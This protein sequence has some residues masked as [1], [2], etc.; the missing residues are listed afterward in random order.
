MADI[1]T[2]RD[3]LR[4]AIGGANDDGTYSDEGYE[5]VHAAINAL[6]PHTPVPNPYEEQEKIQSP[7][8]SLFAQFGPRHT[9]G[10]PIAHET[11]FALMS[12][13]ALPKVPFRLLHLYQ[14]IHAG[15][16]AYNNAKTI[17]N[18]AGDFR[19]TMVVH[20]EYDIDP[21]EPKRYKVDFY[22]AEVRGNNGE[23]DS[24]VRKAFGFAP[25]QPLV[26]DLPRPKLHSDVV[27]CDDELRINFGSMGGVYVMDRLTTP[28]ISVQFG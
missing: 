24:E 18:I 20:G 8:G 27:Y 16:K 3:N 26:V 12:F 21:D 17:E 1:A 28:G 4:D 5:R 25:D 2:L 23:S 9:A 7:W 11:M 14:E 15:T 22:R 10:K 13:G 6:V 19:G